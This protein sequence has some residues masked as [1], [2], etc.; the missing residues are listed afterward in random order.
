MVMIIN[1]T[2]ITI[3]FVF[4]VCYLSEYYVSFSQHRHYH[5]N[6]SRRSS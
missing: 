4:I 3:V 1:V 5:Q 2:V 6:I